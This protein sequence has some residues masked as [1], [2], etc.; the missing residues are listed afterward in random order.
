M[1]SEKEYPPCPLVMGYDPQHEKRHAENGV[2]LSR[3]WAR[4]KAL[5]EAVKKYQRFKD[6]K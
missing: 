5:D 1:K 6:M 4:L 2:V 3:N